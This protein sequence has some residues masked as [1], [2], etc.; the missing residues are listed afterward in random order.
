MAESDKEVYQKLF[1]IDKNAQEHDIRFTAQEDDWK[2]PWTQ[3]TGIPLIDFARKWDELRTVPP[4]NPG[5]IANPSPSNKQVSD[6]QPTQA[7][8]SFRERFDTVSSAR[9]FVAFQAR[10]YL[11]SFPG[12]DAAAGSGSLH[13][14]LRQLLDRRV[15]IY[16][17]A[18]DALSLQVRYRLA[19]SH[20]ATW[21]VKAAQLPMPGGK[22][23]DQW[24]EAEDFKKL[25]RANPTS[26]ISRRYDI[27]VRKI[28]A[29]VLPEPAEEQGLSWNKPN[30]YIA[31]AIAYDDTIQKPEQIQIRVD[32]LEKLAA[33]DIKRVQED[34]ECIPEIRRRKRDFFQKIGKLGGQ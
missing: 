3:R 26:Q 20:R 31:A 33:D 9:E 4:F 2:S 15:Y 24:N 7:T 14:K 29:N 5:G 30:D 17:C 8:G 11:S 32:G 22:C 16:M 6:H 27:A 13:G 1:R 10:V 34:L 25:K 19:M 12:P 23:C 28:F 21:L 18:L